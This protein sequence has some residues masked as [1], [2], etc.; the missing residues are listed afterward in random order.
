MR[1]GAGRVY[2]L[3]V[4]D[5][6]VED[7][8]RMRSAYHAAVRRLDENTAIETARRREGGWT[9]PDPNVRLVPV[10]SAVFTKVY[11]EIFGKP[12][13]PPDG[14]HIT[15]ATLARALDEIYEGLAAK[16][17]VG[18]KNWMRRTWV[19]ALTSPAEERLPIEG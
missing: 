10:R 9:G 7:D 17:D 19:S 18:E 13:W 6:T 12:G 4:N 16:R 1:S 15:S 5:G 2:A 11:R 8:Q 14:Q 3:V